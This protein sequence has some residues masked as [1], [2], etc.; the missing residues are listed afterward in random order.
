MNGSDKDLAVRG[1]AF[2]SVQ[3]EIAS[4]NPKEDTVVY[5]V[6]KNFSVHDTHV[7]AGNHACD[8]SLISREVMQV[9][10]PVTVPHNHYRQ[11]LHSVSV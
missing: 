8:F 10:I 7:L 11:P 4:V 2:P 5:L 9:R 3:L 6:G 1:N